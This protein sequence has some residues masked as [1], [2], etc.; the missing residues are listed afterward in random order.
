MFLLTV[1]PCLVKSALAI[2]VSYT[3]TTVFETAVM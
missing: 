3:P 2:I 1:I